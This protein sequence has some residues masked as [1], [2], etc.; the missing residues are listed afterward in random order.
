M[1]LPFPML[2]RAALLAAALCAGW[3]GRDELPVV[4]PKLSIAR[5]L[6]DAFVSSP[7]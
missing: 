3:F 5:E 1:R 6:I 2:G 7:P 4:P